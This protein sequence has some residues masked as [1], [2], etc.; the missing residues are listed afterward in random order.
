MPRL[1]EPHLPGLRLGKIR[2]QSYEGLDV[3]DAVAAGWSVEGP[4]LLIR[5]CEALGYLIGPLSRD[6][7]DGRA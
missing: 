1:V 4:W 3:Y 6:Q 5:G 7:D 2:R